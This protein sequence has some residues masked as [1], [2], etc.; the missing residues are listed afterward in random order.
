MGSDVV[1]GSLYLDRWL[2]SGWYLDIVMLL[3]LGVSSLMCR[4]NSVVF[5]LPGSWVW[6]WLIWCHLIFLTYRTSWCHIAARPVS[7]RGLWILTDPH[8]H[9]HLLDTHWD[10][11]MIVT[12]RSPLRSTQPGPHFSTL[13]CHHAPP[14][15]RYTLDMC[16]RFSYG[17]RRPFLH[18]RWQMISCRSISD[19]LGIRCP[20]WGIFSVSDEIYGLSGRSHVQWWMISWHLSFGPVAHLMSYWGIF[21]F[22]LRFTD[23]HR[24]ARS[25]P[26]TRYTL[27]RC[28]LRGASRALP[29]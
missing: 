22:R 6:W 5:G 7:F 25:S 16:A 13:G 3:L 27:T 17:F 28:F 9:Y 11:D 21:P 4:S 10:V 1:F 26:L 12:L 20:Y 23:L 24:V 29:S 8:D 2:R 18:V 15:G 14:S 19:L